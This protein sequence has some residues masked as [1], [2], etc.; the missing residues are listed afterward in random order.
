MSS[1]YYEKIKQ[2][3]ILIGEQLI[4]DDEHNKEQ[5]DEINRWLAGQV[6]PRDLAKVELEMIRSFEEMCIM[7]TKEGNVKAKEMTVIEFYTMIGL[8]KKKKI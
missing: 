3:N 2:R 5:I 4:A 6:R 8:I 1:N 7:I